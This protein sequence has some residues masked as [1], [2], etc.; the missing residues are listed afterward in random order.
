MPARRMQGI[1]HEKNHFC[2]RANLLKSSI[3]HQRFRKYQL[4]F[5]NLFIK[6][7]AYPSYIQNKY[8]KPDNQLYNRYVKICYF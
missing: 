4:I 7:P 3:R 8:Y 6:K 2:W 5:C 1:C